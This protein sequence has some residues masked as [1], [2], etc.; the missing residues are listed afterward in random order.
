M[1]EARHA[2]NLPCPEPAA[3]EA[4]HIQRFV[5]PA[6]A[7]IHFNRESLRIPAVRTRLRAHACAGTSLAEPA[8]AEAGG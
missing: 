2:R 1:P 4:R 6:K 8:P 5:I 7:G 3:P